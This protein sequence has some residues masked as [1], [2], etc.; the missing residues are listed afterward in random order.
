MTERSDFGNDHRSN[1][2]EGYKRPARPWE[3]EFALEYY[4]KKPDDEDSADFD[5][6]H[7]ADQDTG[8][9]SDF[10]V[11]HHV[12]QDT[13]EGADFDV[14][15]LADHESGYAAYVEALSRF[16]Y[17]GSRRARGRFVAP[18]TREF[19]TPVFVSLEELRAKQAAASKDEEDQDISTDETG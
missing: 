15:H 14:E 5:V 6:G 2:Q 3:N 8:D 16:R 19:V 10:G 18:D 11:D 12:G 4:G 17:K 7:R 9:T 13:D 1:H